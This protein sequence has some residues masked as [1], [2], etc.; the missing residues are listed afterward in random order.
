MTLPLGPVEVISLVV[1]GSTVEGRGTIDNEFAE[2]GLSLA[3]AE[4][5]KGVSGG[6]RSQS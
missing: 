2:R 6:V 3:T 5:Y 1:A 4:G